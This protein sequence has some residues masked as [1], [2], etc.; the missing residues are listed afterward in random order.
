EADDD[1]TIEAV[2]H[3]GMPSRFELIPVPPGEP[4]TKPKALNL[5]L[6]SARGEIIAVFDAEDRPSP[7]QPREAV[8]AFRSGSKDLAVVQAPLLAHNGADGWF[9]RQFQIEYAI[10]FRVW[11]PF[12]ARAGLPLPLGGT[13]N[14]FCRRKLEAAGGWDAWNV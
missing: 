11:L 2:R 14:Y 4:R 13:S 9:A 1:D 12:L 5:G 8:A 7:D 6:A 10:L 3:S